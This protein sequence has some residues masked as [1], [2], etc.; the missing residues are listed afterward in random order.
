MIIDCPYCE[1]K[2]DADEKGNVSFDTDGLVPHSKF[3]LVECKICH[4]ALL[5]YTELIQVGPDEW[6][7]DNLE[8]YWPKKENTVD[9]EI[10][11]IARVSLIEA[12][13]CFKAKAFSACAVMCGRAIEGVC[14]HHHTKARSLAG[15]L[16][17]LK[18]Q[19]I[20]DSRIYEWGEALRTARN[21][22]AHASTEKVS[23]DDAK[24]LLDFCTAICEYVFVLNVKFERFKARKTQ[25]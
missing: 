5:G 1:S 4:Q 7:W 10:P 13:I 15:G 8:R 20:I 25:D 14:K 9:R 16:K 18:Q 6:D 3:S 21:L 12:V 17:E 11:E 22:G 2:V 19:G 23:M 24:D